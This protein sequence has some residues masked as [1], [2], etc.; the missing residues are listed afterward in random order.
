M[1][2]KYIL[3]CLICIKT[4]SCSCCISTDFH[5]YGAHK[6]E[7]LPCSLPTTSQHYSAS[8]KPASDEKQ[9]THRTVGSTRSM[10]LQGKYNN[11]WQHINAQTSWSLMQHMQAGPGL[12]SLLASEVEQGRSSLNNWVGEHN[13]SASV[14]MELLLWTGRGSILL[15]WQP[16]SPN[17][18]K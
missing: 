7:T 11:N 14:H 3:H 10:P 8:L 13:S 18:W 1:N 6:A 15:P 16:S 4:I 2:V 17:L 12:V 5:V 9:R